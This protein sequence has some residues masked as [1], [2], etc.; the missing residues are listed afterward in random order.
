MKAAKT[1]AKHEIFS[2][3]TVLAAA[4]RVRTGQRLEPGYRGRRRT[5]REIRDAF[6][7]AAKAV[8][9]EYEEDFSPSPDRD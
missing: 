5:Y 1:K 8:R 7:R 4:E 6:I 9:R 2:R 3:E